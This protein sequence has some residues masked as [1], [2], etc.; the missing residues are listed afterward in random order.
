M[1]Y[2]MQRAIHQAGVEERRRQLALARMN[3]VHT[4][5]RDGQLFTVITVPAVEHGDR[6]APGQPPV[7]QHGPITLVDVVS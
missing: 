6:R 2:S 7:R 3:G 5:L 1:G 4:E